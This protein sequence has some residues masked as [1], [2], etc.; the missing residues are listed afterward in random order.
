MMNHESSTLHRKIWWGENDP[1]N[2]QVK[3]YYQINI[4]RKMK[5]HFTEIN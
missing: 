4:I 2:V 3:D 5:L 1:Q